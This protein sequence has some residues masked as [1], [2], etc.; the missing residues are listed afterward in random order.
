MPTFL[1]A[2]LTLSA[3]T[4]A[5]GVT[6]WLEAPNDAPPPVSSRQGKIIELV[7][8]DVADRLDDEPYRNRDSKQAAEVCCEEDQIQVLI[9]VKPLPHSA[10]K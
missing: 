9:P 6:S 10:A 1:M 3:L 2:F 8:K 4:L 7:W 5:G